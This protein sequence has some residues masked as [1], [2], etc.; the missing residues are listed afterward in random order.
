MNGTDERIDSAAPGAAPAGTQ[1]PPRADAPPPPPQTAA[2]T[3]WPAT[4]AGPDPR[5]KSPALACILS[6]LPGLGQVY[7]GY[8]KVGFIHMAVWGSA[9]ALAAHAE[10]GFEALMPLIVLFTIFFYLYNVID[11]GRRAMFYNHALV[12]LEGVEMPEETGLPSPRGSVWGGLALVVVGGVLLSNTL[13]GVSL[14]WL[15]DWWPLAPILV[16][17]WLIARGIQERQRDE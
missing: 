7:V 10:R 17:A 16:G 1:P 9:L 2:A 12:G 3:T 5:R 6:A 4:S 14:E 13:F 11:A 8:Y 15:E